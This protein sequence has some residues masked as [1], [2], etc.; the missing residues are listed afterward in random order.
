MQLQFR[1]RPLIGRFVQA[2]Y[3][4]RIKNANYHQWHYNNQD[5]VK[6][7]KVQIGNAMLG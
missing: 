7:R 5:C 4:Q 3:E 1:A 6:E 2:Y